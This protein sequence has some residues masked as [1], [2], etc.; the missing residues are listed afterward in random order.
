MDPRWIVA[1]E[2]DHLEVLEGNTHYIFNDVGQV[3]EICGR[4]WSAI[5][6]KDL[7][8]WKANGLHPQRRQPRGQRN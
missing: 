7:H 6:H 8:A 1:Q 2:D 3:G 5:E 4:A